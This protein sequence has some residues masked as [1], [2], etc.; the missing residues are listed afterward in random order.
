[1]AEPYDT[2]NGISG[3]PEVWWRMNGTGPG[4]PNEGTT[5]SSND[6]TET[7][8]GSFE[9]TYRAETDPRG[10]GWGVEFNGGSGR[11]LQ[12][13]GTGLN[14]RGT[15]FAL[16]RTNSSFSAT[17]F[18]VGFFNGFDVNYCSVR[19]DGL[20][21]IEYWIQD[22]AADDEI[23]TVV[24][25]VVD[26]TDQQP[27]SVAIIPPATTTGTPL[28]YIDAQ[29]VAGGDLI[30]SGDDNVNNDHWWN[31]F[32]ESWSI[33]RRGSVGGNIPTGLIIYEVIGWDDVLTQQQ[34]QDAHDILTRTA[35]F[36]NKTIRRRGR[37]TFS[38][39]I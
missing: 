36:A 11:G 13:P 7:G 35:V 19:I 24:D 33:G 38:D 9:G 37:R 6:L 5:G 20:G 3:G 39:Q 2:I 30:F 32:N 4:I 8:S 27:H 28:I 23:W 1:M 17:V 18:N 26:M 12:S 15:M 10:D 21:R 31:D 22:G 25:T 34:I 16:W 29:L 14:S